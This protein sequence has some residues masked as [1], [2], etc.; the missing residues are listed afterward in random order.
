MLTLVLTA[1]LL[2]GCVPSATPVIPTATPTA[3]PVFAS[4]A[5]ALAA[6]EAAY[7]AYLKV[8]DEIAHDGGKNPERFSEVVSSAWL[9][10][11]IDSA[12]QLQASGRKQI[13][14]TSLKRVTLESYQGSAHPA[15]VTVYGCLDLSQIHFVDAKNGKNS[16]APP[17]TETPVE[18]ALVTVGDASQKLLI[19]RNGPWTGANFC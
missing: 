6:A 12:R 18:V 4:E 10:Q 16:T 15:V 7:K 9:S 14:D 1:A 8:S 13:G 2:A 3:T 11:E 19:E 17:Q 5:E